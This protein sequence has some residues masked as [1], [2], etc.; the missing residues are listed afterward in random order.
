MSE[1]KSA[2]YKAAK[3]TRRNAKA[4]LTRSGRALLHRIEN[5]WSIEEIKVMLINVDKVYND[6][7]EKHEK[8]TELVE[9]DEEFEV[10]ERWLEE[11]QQQFLSFESRAKKYIDETQKSSDL[12]QISSKDDVQVATGEKSAENNSEIVEATTQMEALNIT[13]T[14]QVE[15]SQVTESESTQV[16]T[17]EAAIIPS[18]K[19]TL[20][21]CVLLRSRNRECLNL[22][23]M[24]ENTQYSNRI[25]NT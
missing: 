2:E 10:D 4:S 21:K 8:F 17:S 19:I 7:V 9:D 11:C 6:L 18:I 23:E 12:S 3:L 24:L 15:T 16:E 5:K 25:L 22:M 20:Q 14:L 1:A 13:E